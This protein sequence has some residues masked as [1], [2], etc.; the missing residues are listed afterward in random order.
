MEALFVAFE[1]CVGV[2]SAS[3]EETDVAAEVCR[4]IVRCYSVSAQFQACRDRLIEMPELVKN[5]CRLLYYKQLTKLCSVAV[6]CVSALATDPILQMHFLQAGVLWHLLLTLF[7]Y[8]HTLEE[9]GVEQNDGENRQAVA[10]S[11]AKLSVHALARMGGYLTEDEHITPDNPIVKEG[12]A[13]MLSPYMAK[14]LHKNEPHQLLKLLTTNSE[15]PYLVWNNGTR[16]E[17]VGFLEE[18]RDR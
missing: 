6:E 12:L 14:Q 4:H 8:D 18:Q 13:A 17:L 11:L 10:N 16:S 1:R 2:L 15:N 7:E 9:S 5:I 3:S